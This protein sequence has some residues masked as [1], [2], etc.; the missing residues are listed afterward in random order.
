MAW[1]TTSSFCPTPRKILSAQRVSK[2]QELVRN[3][4]AADHV[5]RFAVN[6]ARLSR[7]QR[8]DAPEFV[9]KWV[10][11]GA[12]PRASQFLILGAKARAVLHGRYAA[13]CQDVREMAGPALK[14]R[15]IT[16]FHAEAEGVGPDQIISRLL[17][18]VPEDAP[19]R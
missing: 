18:S 9:K 19:A 4:P 17:E 11:W 10:A 12:G 2:L 13:S 14:H 15:I 3:V 8:P 16:N 6:L 1:A 5:I 7:P